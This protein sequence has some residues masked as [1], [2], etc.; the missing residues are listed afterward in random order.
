MGTALAGFSLKQGALRQACVTFGKTLNGELPVPH[1]DRPWSAVTQLRKGHSRYVWEGNEADR[2]D[3][4]RGRGD[5]ELI[6]NKRQEQL[7]RSLVV[8]AVHVR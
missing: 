7:R 1:L 3:D 4:L 2:D 6:E 8:T 5:G